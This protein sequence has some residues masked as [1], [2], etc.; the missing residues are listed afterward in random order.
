[1]EEKEIKYCSDCESHKDNI[2]DNGCW[3]CDIR[4]I[5]TLLDREVARYGDPFDVATIPKDCP[6]GL[7]K[8]A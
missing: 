3:A 6:K 7:S 5:C 1:M 2:I 4:V 8:K